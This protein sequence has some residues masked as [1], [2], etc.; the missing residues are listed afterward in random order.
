MIA[1]NCWRLVRALKSGIDP[2]RVLFSNHLKA[3][4]ITRSNTL[5]PSNIQQITEI[6]KSLNCVKVG[7]QNCE[8]RKV[9]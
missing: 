8:L 1:Y 9:S 5:Q 6:P 4:T 7:L 2:V 3:T